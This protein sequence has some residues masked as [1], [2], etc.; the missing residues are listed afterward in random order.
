MA[1]RQ[2]VI[3]DE[4]VNQWCPVFHVLNF[5]FY[6]WHL[7]HIKK[8]VHDGFENADT[9]ERAKQ[10]QHNNQPAQRSQNNVWRRTDAVCEKLFI[11]LVVF[12]THQMDLKIRTRRTSGTKQHIN[13]LAQLLRNNER[14]E[15]KHIDDNAMHRKDNHKSN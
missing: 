15:K 5:S 9:G 2:G 6:C 14:V 13:Q 7:Q 1:K 10:K 11:L 8:G 3:A 4:P 12:P